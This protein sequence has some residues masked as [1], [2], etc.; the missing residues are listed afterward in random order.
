MGYLILN[1]SFDTKRSKRVL[2]ILD[3]LPTMSSATMEAQQL[4]AIFL[5]HF[6]DATFEEG[7]VATNVAQVFQP[8][9]FIDFSLIQLLRCHIK[10]MA[11]TAAAS[12]YI[13]PGSF[14]RIQSPPWELLR[15][16]FF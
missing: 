2:H 5:K 10:Q 14:C 12:P 13:L 16:V 15:L 1:L 8:R 4:Q 11:R 6:Q 3:S 9:L 7:R